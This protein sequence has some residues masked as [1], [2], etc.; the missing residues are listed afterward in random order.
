MRKLLIVGLAIMVVASP[1]Y[2]VVR[3]NLDLAEQ[4][5]DNNA[6]KVTGQE[7]TVSLPVDDSFRALGIPFM[8]SGVT[9]LY[10]RSATLDANDLPYQFS[11]CIGSKVSANHC[12]CEVVDLRCDK[13]LIT[14]VLRDHKD[15]NAFLDSDS[16]LI[17]N[18]NAA[19]IKVKIFAAG[20]DK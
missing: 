9:M 10:L 17:R 11:L 14:D 4:I 3:V 18:P 16:I 5:A 6:W 7:F 20:I 13:F 19:A 12:S 1:C 15:G 8:D 2:G